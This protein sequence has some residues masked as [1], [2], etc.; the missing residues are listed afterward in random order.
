M[1]GY[2]QEKIDENCGGSYKSTLDEVTAQILTSIKG[3]VTPLSK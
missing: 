1:L 3:Q 2:L